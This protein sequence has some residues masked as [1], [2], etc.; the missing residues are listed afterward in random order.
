MSSLNYVVPGKQEFVKTTEN[1]GT[2]PFRFPFLPAHSFP[3]DFPFHPTIP[4]LLK[5]LTPHSPD[6][7]YAGPSRFI[8]CLEISYFSFI[9]L[10]D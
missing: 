6:P 2:F 7:P 4:S 5:N 10:F 9:F 3:P 8:F 1:P